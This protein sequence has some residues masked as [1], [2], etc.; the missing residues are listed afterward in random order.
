MIVTAL[1]VLATLLWF[2]AWVLLLGIRAALG[3]VHK[4]MEH[5]FFPTVVASTVTLERTSILVLANEVSSLP[6][7]ADLIRIVVEELGLAAEVL[8]VM[9]IN[10]LGLVVL[11]IVWTPLR[12]EEVHVEVHVTGHLV[13]QRRLNIYVRV[14]EGTV[15]S[16]LALLLAFCTE[17]C[18]VAFNVVQTLHF[19]VRLFTVR[20]L[21]KFLFA[22]IN[23]IVDNRGAPAFIR[24]VVVVGALFGVVLR[25]IRTLHCLKPLQVHVGS[26]LFVSI[27][28]F[29]V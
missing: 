2:L 8:P 19:V 17:L 21:T 16:V 20:C 9:R 13:D 14:R 22:E 26:A 11:L 25:H 15:L 1:K 18:F 29:F 24:W 10:A 7:F 12:L 27:P 5:L 28:Q 3:L 23:R 6:L 4:W